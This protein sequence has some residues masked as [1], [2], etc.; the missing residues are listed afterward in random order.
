LLFSDLGAVGIDIH[1]RIVLP[2]CWCV[3]LTRA[4]I[5]LESD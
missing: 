2:S 1:A 5:E 4:T 3:L